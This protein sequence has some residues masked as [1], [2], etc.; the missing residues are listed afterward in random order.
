MDLLCCYLYLYRACDWR[1]PECPQGQR[2]WKMAVDEA[3]VKISN[4]ITQMID[5][6]ERDNRILSVID[7]EILSVF[8]SEFGLLENQVTDIE[9]KLV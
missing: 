8:T 9:C 1:E 6:W 2:K 5:G 7:R 3:A 4:R